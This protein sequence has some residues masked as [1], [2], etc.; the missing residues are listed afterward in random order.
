MQEIPL[1]QPAISELYLMP[2]SLEMAEA[3]FPLMSAKICE[4]LAIKPIE[5][6]N[7]VRH[8]IKGTDS[9]QKGRFFIVHHSLGIIGGIS[10]GLI[11][12]R[13]R[14]I[15]ALLSYW[16]GDEYQGNGYA[17]T[18]LSSLMYTL[19][20][21]GVTQYLA[22]VFPYNIASQKVLKKLGFEC[23]DPN[24]YQDGFSGLVDFTLIL[25]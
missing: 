20:N 22:Q 23:L 18:A 24:M 6:I 10:F 9:L 15:T 21:Q 4:G 11:N 2:V 17:T 5:S 14:L 8:F 1:R 25:I 13:E 3:I 19:K 7:D 12:D 16:V